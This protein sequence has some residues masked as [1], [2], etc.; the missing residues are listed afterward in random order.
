M[1]NH[2]K[3]TRIFF[4]FLFTIT[5]SNNFFGQKCSCETELEFVINYYETNLPG[6]IDNVSDS[7]RLEYENFKKKLQTN[8]QHE[9]DKNKCFKLL[10]FYVEFFK[11]FSCGEILKKFNVMKNI[12]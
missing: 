6:F 1:N 5:L 10:T 9:N 7:N 12:R 8:G 3:N 4:I 11:I 2:L